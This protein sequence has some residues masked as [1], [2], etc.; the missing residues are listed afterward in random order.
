MVFGKTV[1]Q[2]VLC[3]ATSGHTCPMVS[4][5]IEAAT[6]VQYLDSLQLAKR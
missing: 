5:M 1:S 2:V 3:S 6:S 4:C